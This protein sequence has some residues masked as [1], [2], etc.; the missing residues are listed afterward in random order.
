M[1]SQSYLSY[2]LSSSVQQYALFGILHAEESINQQLIVFL[3]PTGLLALDELHR[4]LLKGGGKSR[5]DVTE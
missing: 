2:Q 4:L 1:L 5:Q 3:Q